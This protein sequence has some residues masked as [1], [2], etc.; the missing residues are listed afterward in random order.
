MN[1]SRCDFPFE[2]D[3]DAVDFT[4]CPSCGQEMEIEQKITNNTTKPPEE[5]LEPLKKGRFVFTDIQEGS[6]DSKRTITFTPPLVVGYTIW[7]KKN[8]KT[9]KENYP[10]DVPIMG[11]VTYDF[12][13]DMSTPLDLEHNWLVNGYEGLSKE[14]SLEDI[15]M[16]SV[17][18]DLFHSFCHDKDDP[19]Y[20]HYNWA[21]YG[22]LKGRA[23]VKETG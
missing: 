4:A 11:F 15:L 6:D 3:E 12:G 18:Y 9:G 7:E 1:C 23:L 19:N 21:L 20:G 17:I 2:P 22:N 5:I 10:E 13:M 14:S 16:Y 8:A